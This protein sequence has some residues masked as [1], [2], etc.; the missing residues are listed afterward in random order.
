LYTLAATIHQ[1]EVLNHKRSLTLAMIRRLHSGLG[2]S[3]E[4]LIGGSGGGSGTHR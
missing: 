1:A 2:I 3:A 4:V